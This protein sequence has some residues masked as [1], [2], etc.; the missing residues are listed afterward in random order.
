MKGLEMLKDIQR[1]INHIK[2]VIPKSTSKE[3]QEILLR[4]FNRI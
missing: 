3:K 1:K 2:E 4:Y